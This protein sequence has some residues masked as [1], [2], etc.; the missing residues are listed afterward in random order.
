MTTPRGPTL[1]GLVPGMAPGAWKRNVIVLLVYLLLFAAALTAAGV[2][3]PSDLDPGALAASGSCVSRRRDGGR[4]Q[5]T[6]G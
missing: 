2:G 3:I 4:R 5:R 6:P 1:V